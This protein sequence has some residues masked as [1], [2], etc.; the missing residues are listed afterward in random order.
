M[1]LLHVS[2]PEAEGPEDVQVDASGR[3]LTGTGDGRILRFTL[4]EAGRTDHSEVLART[5]GRPLGLEVTADDGLL[6]CD[7]RRG[8]LRV[9]T[10]AGSVEVLADEVDGRPLRFCS[11]VTEASDGTVYFTVSSRR[12][13]LEAWLG[14]ILEHTGTGLLVRLRPGGEP[15]VL[16]DGLQFANGVA[17]APDESFLIVA[18]TGAYRLTRFW[19]TG[20]RAGRRDT[21]LDGLPG[22]PDNISRSPG[23][24]YWIAIASPR[25]PALDWL[26]RRSGTVR[27][28]AGAMGAAVTRLRA[29]PR[30]TVRVLAVDSESRIVHDLV[31]RR[32]PYRMVTSVCAFGDGLVLGSL[33]ERGVAV[34]GPPRT[35]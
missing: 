7:A 35:R 13:G 11:N 4:D 16:L 27:R 12:H 25:E 10:R 2:A 26:H 8:L 14:D 29:R 22:F 6:V 5:G 15:E 33:N 34:C 24:L 3:V 17:L 21:F 23:G 9:D 19:L 1:A 31:L 18:E 20:P 28:A 32:S 30:T